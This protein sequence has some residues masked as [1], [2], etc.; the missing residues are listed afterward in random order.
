MVSSILGSREMRKNRWV[1]DGSAGKT[2]SHQGILRVVV[3]IIYAV[4]WFVPCAAVSRETVAKADQICF[5]MYTVQ[6]DVLKMTVQLYPLASEDSRT[7]KLQLHQEDRWKTVATE[8]VR[9]SSY[10]NKAGD[11]AWNVLFKEKGW[12]HSR[13]WKYRVVALEGVAE[14]TG[15]IRRDPVDKQEIVVAAFT[16]NSNQDRRLKPDLIANIQA[17][18]PDL[19]FFSGDQSY[20]HEYHLD[21][22][23]LFGRQ[24]GDIIRDR[25]TIC[26]PDD[27]DVGQANLWGANGKRAYGPGGADGGYLMPVEYVNE[28]QFAQTAN[29]PDPFDS[30]PIDRG[31]GVYYTSLNVGGIDFAIIEDRKF[32]TGPMG[33]VEAPGHPRPDLINDPDYDPK[34]VDVPE[35]KLLGDRQLRFL[36]EWGED[37]RGVQ[38]KAVLSQTIFVN[39]AHK[40]G[41]WR[42]V[43]D[44]DSNGWP[45][46]GRN[47]ALAEIRKSFAFMLAGDQHLGSVI[48]HGID[49]WDDAG[50]SFCVPSIVN[51]WPRSWLPETK[52]ID[53]VSEELKYTGKFYDGFGNKLTMH[54]YSNP[55][56]NWQA[57]GTYDDPF[58]GGA[59]GHGIV[60]FDK[61]QRTITMECWPRNTDV[62]KPDAMQY[63]GWPVTVKQEDNYGRKAVA[64]LPELVVKGAE[65]PVVQVVDE[66]TNEVIYTLR[67]NG[68]RWQPKVFK[69]GRY[70]IHV[71]DEKVRKTFPH[72]EAAAALN[73][74]LECTFN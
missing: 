20:D 11:R 14:Y 7:V 66:L 18:D 38:M 25:P 24:F 61:A 26:I 59:A 19:L 12:D 36:R 2:S 50:F 65:D 27:H 16:G 57:I 53:P 69:P 37:W 4:V 55:G 48:H 29:L 1:F 5:A 67:I 52:G 42:V 17:H 39:A 40:T 28:V 44:L 21:A 54:A 43:A 64:W 3:L 47:R 23:L 15:L 58:V 9:E 74:L 73:D 41:R 34:S 72:I 60:R 6:N 32:K 10:G 31:I 8:K 45:Q 63:K 35:A 30:T 13:D 22:W 70:T 71:E 62:T 46:A 49:E 33:L 51:A 68:A 56:N